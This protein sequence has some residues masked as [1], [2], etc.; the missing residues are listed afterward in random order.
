MQAGQHDNPVSFDNVKQ[1]IREAAQTHTSYVFVDA[2]IQQRVSLKYRFDS[3]DL[4]DEGY[5]Q[6]GIPR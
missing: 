4:P 1:R 3:L 5:A 2:L 6:L